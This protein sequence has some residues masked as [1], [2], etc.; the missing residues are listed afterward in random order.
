MYAL[1]CILSG[2]NKRKWLDYQSCKK[3]INSMYR[4]LLSLPVS[5]QFGVKQYIKE[6]KH[7]SQFTSITQTNEE[8]VGTLFHCDKQLLKKLEALYGVLNHK[9]SLQKQPDFLYG[10]RPSSADVYLFAHLAAIQDVPSTL[11]HILS[12]YPFLQDYYQRVMRMYFT[13]MNPD[14]PC[15]D[16]LF[17]QKRGLKIELSNQKDCFTTRKTPCTRRIEW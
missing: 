13:P 8:E 1:N 3:V 4:P 2:Q 6:K 12:D 9:L 11:S 7:F 17:V 15:S 5:L 14:T 16:N 10:Y